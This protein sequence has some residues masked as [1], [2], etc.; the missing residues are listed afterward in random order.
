MQKHEYYGPRENRTY[1]FEK[2]YLE[3]QKNK[4]EN[5]DAFDISL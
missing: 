2:R 4:Q 1:E 3:L 5:E